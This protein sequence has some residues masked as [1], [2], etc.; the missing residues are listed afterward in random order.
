MTIDTAF[1]TDDQTPSPIG[2]SKEL[3]SQHVPFSV[4]D[5]TQYFYGLYCLDIQGRQSLYFPPQIK[6]LLSNK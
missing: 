4:I 6:K 2:F 3:A 1:V 5:T